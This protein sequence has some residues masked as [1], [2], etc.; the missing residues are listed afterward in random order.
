MNEFASIYSRLLLHSVHPLKK[1]TQRFLAQRLRSCTY[2]KGELI[3]KEGEVFTRLGMIRKGLVRGF[4]RLNG[5][6]ISIWFSSED[7]LFTE[8]SFFD[9]SPS[10]SNIEA[11]ENMTIEYLEYKDYKECVDRFED[12]KW[13][14]IKLLGTYYGLAELRIVISR[15]PNASSRL[16]YLLETYDIEMLRRIPN[17]HLAN[18][19]AMRPETL[20]RLAAAH[21]LDITG[22]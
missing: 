2:K 4:Y 18:F 7:D 22:P 14:T 1:E 8:A 13:L 20:S 19:L 17:K 11:L 6:E 5:H 15:I 21:N 9:Q 3:C 12:F 10:K 16:T